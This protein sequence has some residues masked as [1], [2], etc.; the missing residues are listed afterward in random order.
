MVFSGLAP[1][2]L[3]AHVGRNVSRAAAAAYMVF[4]RTL[5]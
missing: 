3:V 2:A 5:D 1:V 4:K